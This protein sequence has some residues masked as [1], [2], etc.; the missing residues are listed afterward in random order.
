[1]ASGGF[2]LGNAA[3]DTGASVTVTGAGTTLAT[4]NFEMRGGSGHSFTVANGATVTAGQTGV[5]INGGVGNP[6]AGQSNTTFTVTGAGSRFTMNGGLAIDWFDYGTGSR[7][8]I[9]NG[10]VVDAPGTNYL[11]YFGGANN[12][13]VSI[14]GSGSLWNIAN[15]NGAF[16]PAGVNNTISVSNFGRIASSGNFQLGGQSGATVGNVLN[17]SGGGQI[18]VSATLNANATGNVVNLGDGGTLSTALVNSM[19]L[20]GT[21]SML[22][23]N[24]G[25]LVANTSGNLV[26]GSGLIRL[27]GATFISSASG[28]TSNITSTI[29]GS[30]SLTKED[31]GTLVLNAIN[32]YTGNTVVNGGVLVADATNFSTGARAPLNA[33]TALTL[34]NGT[35]RFT[36]T[37]GLSRTQVVNGLALNPGSNVVDANHVNT[38][39]GFASPP[40]TTI[41]LSG[42]TGLLGI[43]RNAGAT[44]DFRATTG[45]YGTT[46]IV[47]SAQANNATNILGAWATV[48]NGANLAANNGSNVIVAYAGYGSLDAQAGGANGTVLDNTNANLRIDAAGTSGSVPIAGAVTNINTLLQNFGTASIIDT[49]PGVLRVGIDGG[50]LISSS[51]QNLTIGTGANLGTLTAGGNADN[52]AGDLVLANFSGNTLTVNSTIADNVAGVVTVSKTGGGNVVLNGTSNSFTGTTF[53]N[54]GTLTLGASDVIGTGGVTINGGTL[55]MGTNS[56]SV[57]AVALTAGSITGFGG[58][59]LT[60]T[61]GF[62]FT[63]PGA[64]TISA[65]LAGSVGITKS[66]RGIV[67]LS[68]A[69]TFNGATAVNEGVLKAGVVSVANTSGAFGNNSAITMGTALSAGLDITGFN[70]QIGSLTGGGYGAGGVV[71]GSATLSVGGDGTSPAAYLGPISGTGGVTKIGGGTWTVSGNSSYTGITK[72]DSGVLDLGFRIANGG[73]ASSMGQSTN[74]AANLVIGGGTLRYSGTEATRTD[75]LFTIGSA[76]GDTAVIDASGTGAL[77]FTN[78]GPIAFGNTNP[79]T[80]TLTGS[81]VGANSLAPVISDNTGQTS[82]VKD[83]VGSWTLAS[84]NT[85]SGT[86]LVNAGTLALGNVNALQNSTLDTGAAG[87]Q[88]VTFA[89]TGTNTYNLGGLQGADAINAGANSLSVGANN[90]NAT[91]TGDGIGAA[92]TKVGTA[93]QDLNG[94]SQNYGTL[95]VNDGT[96]NVN[97]TLGTGSSVVTVTDTIGLPATK[98]RFGTV[99]QTLSSLTIGAGATVVF[100]SGTASGAFSGGDGGGKAPSFGG[101]AV[102]PEPG[103]IGLLLVGAL[104]MM[105]R[106]RRQ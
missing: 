4:N 22:N 8:I 84:A 1:L 29:V 26:T 59:T 11:G 57:G 2:I 15:L 32:D 60:S 72:I 77:A 63:N 71:L 101:G 35:F 51:G 7:L 17:I 3:A 41:D 95:A 91:F 47:R 19:A 56:D 28:F 78:S 65:A 70:T 36:G 49:T 82:V 48:N 75:R 69:S 58:A 99:S 93:V 43:T 98:L 21:N 10:G 81:N 97:G 40:T 14:D 74:A 44:V 6:N 85:H 5:W 104:G 94:T 9:G 106:R 68:G 45:T 103:T 42:T 53:V 87:A 73:I 89:V 46:A 102:V 79:H 23:F 86:T 96:L 25:R 13:S 66:A 55:A 50:I 83:G 20:T 12:N 18:S 62:T 52:V 67:T 16:T 54:A 39:T 27:T 33:A 30:G 61:S 64:V 90:T 100:T 76:A 105:G 80:L 92:F 37:Q 31:A 24:N 38:F 34:S 88:T